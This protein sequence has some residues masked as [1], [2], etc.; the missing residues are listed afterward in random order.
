MKILKKKRFIT[1]LLS[2]LLVVMTVM[3]ITIIAVDQAPVNLGTT[4]NFAVL[5]SSTITNTGTTTINGSVGGDVGLYPGS[6]FVGQANMSI[7]GSVHIGDAVAI[8]AKSNLVDAYNDAAG[9]LPEFTIPSELGGVTLTP[10]TYKSS[11]GTF[12]ITGTLTLD[13]ENDPNGVFIFKTDSTLVTASGS[14]IKLENGARFCRT[15]WK[16][17]SSATL[18]TN[19]NFVGHILASESITATTGAT[20]QGQ[21]LALNGAVTLDSNTITNGFCQTIA[22]AKSATLN[23]IKL[24]I[25]DEGGTL[26]ASDFEIHVMSSGFDVISSPT[27]GERAPGTT[28]ILDAGAYTVSEGALVGYTTTY[29]GDSDVNGNITLVAGDNKSVIVTNNDIP[30]FIPPNAAMLHVIKH[31]INDD[32]GTLIVSDVNIHVKKSSGVDVSSSPKP[33]EGE[34]GT[35]YLLDSGIYTIIE[36]AT[37]GYTM[38]FSGDCDVN[39]NIKLAP[40]DDKTVTIINDDILKNPNTEDSGS[41]VLYSI[42]V[43]LSGVILFTLII[44]KR[45]KV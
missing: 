24:V 37:D 41:F 45:K 26:I 4:I 8:R 15:F 32:G 3:P 44:S 12:K 42:F 6:E 18:G 16:V 29:S 19:S 1:L 38:S 39:G 23:V 33:G 34:P 5:A 28:Y 20:V 40:G 2:I 27:P 35:I 36:D 30:P 21:L 9:R 25:N 7:S 14:N 43:I 22:T 10:G 31:V 17:G 11:D 13:A